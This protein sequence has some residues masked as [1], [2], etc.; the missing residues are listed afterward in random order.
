[1][2]LKVRETT[3]VESWCRECREEVSRVR[4]VRLEKRECDNATL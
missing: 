2:S 1:M 3:R 4:W